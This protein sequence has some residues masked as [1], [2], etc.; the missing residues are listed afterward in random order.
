MLTDRAMVLSHVV[1]PEKTVIERPQDLRTELVG[2]KLSQMSAPAEF[3]AQIPA[4]RQRVARSFEG[5]LLQRQH[6]SEADL[7]DAANLLLELAELGA[8]DSPATEEDLASVM[9]V[10]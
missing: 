2:I 4:F 1:A 10:R 7:D 8:Y 6:A 3:S 9:A 5:C